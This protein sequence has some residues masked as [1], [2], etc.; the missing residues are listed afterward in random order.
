MCNV[1]DVP[2]A[3]NLATVDLII[4]AL[5]VKNLPGPSSSDGGRREGRA[6]DIVSEPL[7]QLLKVDILAKPM[8]REVVDAFV[9]PE[10]ASSI[11]D[12]ENATRRR[13]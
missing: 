13:K 6:L 8:K 2:V 11:L 4:A 5:P 10:R 9:E 3:T 7:L 12:G 1:H